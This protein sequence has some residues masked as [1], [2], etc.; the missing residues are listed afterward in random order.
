[1]YIIHINPCTHTHMECI[2]IYIHM[3]AHMHSYVEFWFI[4]VLAG[5]AIPRP[6]IGG[7]SDTGVRSKSCDTSYEYE[8]E[9]HDHSPLN[10][11]G[12]CQSLH[13]F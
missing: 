11:E 6:V 9:Y 1:M 10:D 3:R 2:H 13:E 7:A 4:Y 8:L 12:L 5:Q